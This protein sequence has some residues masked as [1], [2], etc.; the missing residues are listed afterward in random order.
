MVLYNHL[1]SSSLP[2]SFLEVK[3]KLETYVYDHEEGTRLGSS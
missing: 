2:P 3:E 1:D